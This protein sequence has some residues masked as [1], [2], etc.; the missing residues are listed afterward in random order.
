MHCLVQ[1]SLVRME[2]LEAVE[3]RLHAEEDATHRAVD[4]GL[5]LALRVAAALALR[6]P[7]KYVTISIYSIFLRSQLWPHCSLN[8]FRLLYNRTRETF[9]LTKLKT[10][11][12][13]KMSPFAAL[14]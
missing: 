3:A 4:A 13:G 5:L 7:L 14:A 11:G 1:Y 2:V 6:K 10:V 8:Q 12:L 9:F